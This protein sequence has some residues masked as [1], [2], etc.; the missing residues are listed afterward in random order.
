M[1]SRRGSGTLLGEPSRAHL[2]K[3]EESEGICWVGPSTYVSVGVYNVYGFEGTDEG[4]VR[5]KH[6]PVRSRPL[7]RMTYWFLVGGFLDTSP[8][9]GRGQGPAFPH[10]S[11]GNAARS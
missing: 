2:K 8:G 1:H 10:S 5:H 6:P 3:A 11:R 9:P 7:S 4:L